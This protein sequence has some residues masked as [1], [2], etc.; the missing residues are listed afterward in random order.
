MKSK[1]ILLISL[2][3]FLVCLNG[4]NGATLFC[5]DGYCDTAYEEENPLSSM[6]CPVDCGTRVNETWCNETYPRTCPSCS[7]CCSPCGSSTCDTSRISNTELR[8]WCSNDG[9]TKSESMINCPFPFV[10]K[11]AF[12][13][14][15]GNK[16][17]DGLIIIGIFIFIVTLILSYL[18]FYR[19]KKR[20]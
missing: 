11:I 10:E 18:L 12:F 2:A 5:G 19:R 17:K 7:S 14:I 13:K 20:R 4:I 6:Y 3:L 16:C 15:T 1:L 8:N 9:Y